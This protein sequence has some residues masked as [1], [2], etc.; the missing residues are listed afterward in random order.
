MGHLRAA[1]RRS[2]RSER[3]YSRTL[4]GPR[5]PPPPQP[6][7]LRPGSQCAGA[8]PRGSLGVAVHTLGTRSARP[9]PSGRRHRG[10]SAAPPP[11]LCRPR[12]SA[13]DCGSLGLSGTL[14]SPVQSA[15]A[16]LSRHGPSLG[17]ATHSAGATQ[18]RPAGED[19][20]PGVRGGPGGDRQLGREA[21][22][23]AQPRYLP[24]VG[25]ESLITRAKRR[26]L[27]RRWAVGP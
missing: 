21:R 17:S 15:Q 18:E 6:P 20:E 10:A 19:P 13:Q 9:L 26:L 25:A 23:L 3:P 24:V 7:L 4:E 1:A 8:G 14:V 12:A 11:G 5:G 27:F 2:D 22:I 16:S